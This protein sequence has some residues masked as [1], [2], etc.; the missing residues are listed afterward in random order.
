MLIPI[1]ISGGDLTWLEVDGTGPLRLVDAH[2]DPAAHIAKPSPQIPPAKPRPVP[3][4]P[5]ARP[6]PKAA[7]PARP[8]PAPGTAPVSGMRGGTGD[9]SAVHLKLRLVP[10][11]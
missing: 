4:T 6:Q 2:G 11:G 8:L 1:Y 7:V 10:F 5:I 9:G 3:P